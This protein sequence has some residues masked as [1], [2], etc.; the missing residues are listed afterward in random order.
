MTVPKPI[1]EV[2]AIFEDPFNLAK[3]TPP[4]LNFEIL[5]PKAQVRMR[6]GLLI[7]YRFSWLGLPLYWQTLITC[8]RPPYEFIDK[9]LKGPYAHWHHRHEFR[10]VDGG[11]QVIDTVDYGLPL[12]PLGDLA[13]ALMVRANV[14]GIF[15]HRQKVLNEYWGGNA[16]IVW[17]AV[18]A[19]EPR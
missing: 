8:Y 15:T 4:W 9:A 19:M 13:H 16:S 7:D 3:I 6:E 5:T 11:T 1:D 14:T 18:T 2:F 17:P 10:A 12:G